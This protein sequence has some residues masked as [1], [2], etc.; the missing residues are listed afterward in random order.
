MDFR[1]TLIGLD[2]AKDLGS[3]AEPILIF[4]NIDTS[5]CSREVDFEF[6]KVSKWDEQAV[7]GDKAV[8]FE[9]HSL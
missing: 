6:S 4:L 9:K 2:R 8:F 7:G 5:V 3:W 1:T